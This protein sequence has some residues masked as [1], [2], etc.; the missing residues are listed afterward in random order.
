MKAEFALTAEVCTHVGRIRE[1]NEDSFLA[2]PEVLAV[3]DGLG[4]HAGGDVASA[5]AIEALAEFAASQSITG[6]SRKAGTRTGTRKRGKASTAEA[7]RQAFASAHFAVLNRAASDVKLQEMCTTLCALA[8][9]QEGVIALANVGDS[10]IYRLSDGD[11]VQ[12]TWDH[13]NYNELI[14]HHG[15]SPTEAMKSFSPTSLSRV[16]GVFPEPAEVDTWEYEAVAGHRYLLTSDG[17]TGELTDEEIAEVLRSFEEPADA[18]G[19][20]VQQ[21]NDRGG[22]DNITVVVADISQ[23]EEGD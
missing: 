17:L 19:E 2:H 13:I 21:A 1:R 12:L 5:I 20:L 4:G 7:L 22:R 11:L 18:A 23:A 9:D 6:R 8:L 3:A 16:L 14:R 15:C 10:R